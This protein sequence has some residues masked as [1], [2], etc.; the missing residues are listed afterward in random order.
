[1]MPRHFANWSFYWFAI[2]PSILTNCSVT[3][4]PNL[5]DIWLNHHFTNFPFHQLDFW[6]ITVS[7]TLLIISLPFCQITILLTCHFINL[8]FWPIAV[9]PKVLIF[10]T[11]DWI[12]ILP[13]WHFHQPSVLSNYSFTNF[14]Y[15][16]FAIFPN[17]YFANLSF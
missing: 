7:P 2:F 16:I 8:V 6:P 11:F 3:K 14:L 9:S 5:F 17:H 13:T 4:A 1:M 12:I 10:L 15:N